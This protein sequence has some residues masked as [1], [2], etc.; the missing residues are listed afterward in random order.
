M[1][2]WVSRHSDQ[3]MP[4]VAYSECKLPVHQEGN[5]MGLKKRRLLDGGEGEHN[6]GVRFLRMRESGKGK[7]GSGVTVK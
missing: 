4:E 1:G 3:S 6:Q 2:E 7:R 5:F